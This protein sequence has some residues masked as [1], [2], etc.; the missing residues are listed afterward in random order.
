MKAYIL[1]HWSYLTTKGKYPGVDLLRA[2][3]VTL[4]TLYHFNFMPFGWVGVDIFFVLS[5]FLIGGIILDD[6]LKNN[7][8]FK[9]FY[10]KR[11]FRILPLYYFVLAFG[12]LFKNHAT[13]MGVVEI[14]TIISGLLFLQTTGAYF[15]PDLFPIN[16]EYVVGGSWSLVIEEMF[17]IFAPLIIFI[18]CKVTRNNL[19]LL[20]AAFTMIVFSGV[21]TRLGM[22]SSF[23]PDDPNWHFASFIQFHSRYDE[24]AMGVALAI[25][26]RVFDQASLKKNSEWFLFLG[27]ISWLLFFAFLKGKP[28][29]WDKPW[30][31]ARD[32]V[33]LPLLFSLMGG[34]TLLG[35]YWW[36]VK[37]K[38]LILLARLSYA[39]YL[40]HILSLE[41]THMMENQALFNYLKNVF[42]IWGFFVILISF[43]IFLSYIVSLLVEYPFIKLYRK[44]YSREK[45]QL[46]SEL[47]YAKN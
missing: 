24:I 33:W 5:G 32:T 19:K 37:S 35:C 41:T 21:L 44:I 4:V 17:Y 30:E 23:A 36:D 14:K 26:I 29:Y 25:V 31:I 34:F 43:V 20:L 22:T 10:I 18:L 38:V 42:S 46:K 40:I 1:E 11:A 8:S 13:P 27:L 12:V 9:E 47:A 15:F 16:Q 2:I 45:P 39:I 3:A 28:V 6:I 7:F